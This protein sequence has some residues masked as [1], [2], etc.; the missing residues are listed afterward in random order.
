MSATFTAIWEWLD[1]SAKYLLL[2]GAVI[3][4]LYN[5][6]VNAKKYKDWRARRVAR[7]QALE[8]ILANSND[9]LCGSAVIENIGRLEKKINEAVEDIEEIKVNFKQTVR[10]N[11]RQD[12]EIRRSAE[13]RKLLASGLFHLLQDHVDKGYNGKL[14]DIRSQMLK[15]MQDESLRIFEDA[16]DEKQT[17]YERIQGVDR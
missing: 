10:H 15:Y 1:N 17:Y 13:H 16:D 5:L 2:V 14:S 4:A 3:G 7:S 11:I 8:N 12:I 9:F 6:I